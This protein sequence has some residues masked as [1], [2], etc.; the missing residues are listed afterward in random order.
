MST[1]KI[2]TFNAHFF[3]RE[4]T[5]PF[6]P[7][8]T[9]LTT[10][11]SVL[12]PIL[13]RLCP[14]LFKKLDPPLRRGYFLLIRRGA[15]FWPL[16]KHLL[17]SKTP[18]KVK[19]INFTDSWAG[20]VPIVFPLYTPLFT[21]LCRSRLSFIIQLGFST[22]GRF[23]RDNVDPLYTAPSVLLPICYTAY[24][25]YCNIWPIRQL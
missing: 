8:S 9:S 23:T 3:W 18:G 17:G 10:F 25:T 12:N 20:W 24:P 16:Q 1:F 15:G 13:F 19:T 14:T 2:I 6:T 4:A 21:P 5:P 7:P 22:D 11:R